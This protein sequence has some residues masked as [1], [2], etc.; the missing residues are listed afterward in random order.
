M[1]TVLMILCTM[2]TFWVPA[3]RADAQSDITEMESVLDRLERRLL[4][5]ERATS[6]FLLSD[7]EMEINSRNEAVDVKGNEINI[8]GDLPENDELRSLARA[9]NDIEAEVDRLVG[10]IQRTSQKVIEHSKVNNFIQLNAVVKD[11]KHLIIRYL[12][13]YINDFEVY[14]I[15][16]SRSVHMPQPQ[17]PLFAG[18]LEPG[19]HKMK[20]A[21][22]FTEIIDDGLPL[23][24]GA[25]AAVEGE[26]D[27]NV[28]PGAFKK[29]WNIH[30][31]KDSSGENYRLKLM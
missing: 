20:V 2:V 27:L 21:V 17:F 9:L 25:F 1:K 29:T 5:R 30:M 15:D 23:K 14:R 11:P 16:L 31:V 8:N 18:P 12:N 28:P 26:F 3:E 4:N 10:D 19:S 6:S 24:Q 22:K 13:V 7:E